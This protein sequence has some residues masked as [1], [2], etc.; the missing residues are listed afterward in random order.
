[1]KWQATAPSNIALIKYMGK[2]S[3]SGNQA[4]N[5]SLSYTLSDLTTSVE[6]ELIDN[7]QDIWQPLTGQ[8]FIF[9]P[10]EQQ[11]YLNHLNF[12]KKQLNFSGS[13]LVR[14]ANNFP[15]GCGLASSA[16]S[17]AALTLCA[18]KAISVLDKNINLSIEKIAELSRYGSGSSCRSFFSPWALWEEEKICVINLPYTDLLHH[19]VLVSNEKKIVNSSSAHKNV[20]TSLLF[21]ERPLRAK[22]RLQELIKSLDEKNWHQAYVIVWQEFWDMHLLFETCATPFSY[23]LP[24][25]LAVLNYLRNYWKIYNDGPLVTMDAGTNI[26]LLFRSDQ[27]KMLEAIASDIK[28]DILNKY[29]NSCN[30]L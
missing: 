27:K 14:S 10:G 7:P 30:N 18:V 19:V 26:H 13:F 1:M 4:Y 20:L 6:L 25:T 28:E 16:S 24:S 9:S 5:P 22:I 2:F 15:M 21:Q 11:R 23:M 3:C 17:F 8:N 12:V 29:S